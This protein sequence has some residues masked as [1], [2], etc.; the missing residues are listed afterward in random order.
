V[1]E[2]FQC[3]L[4]AL[5]HDMARRYPDH[6][7]LVY[8]DRDLRYSFRELDERVT[9]LAKGL[10]AL[11]IRKG[12]HVGIW[13]TNVPDWIPIMF[14]TARIGAVLVTVNTSYRPKE[15]E[16]VLQQSDMKALFTID[17]YRDVDYVQEI[18]GLVPELKSG[19][20]GALRSARFPFLERV[21]YLGPKK[22]RGMH[23]L[24][25]VLRLA[26]EAGDVALESVVSSLDPH[27]VINMQYTS[28]TTGFPKGVML[29]HHSI[30]NNGYQIGERQMFTHR[31]RL[32]LPVPLFHCF[33][34]TLGVLAAYT[35]G[36]TIVPLETFDPLMVLAVVQKERCTALYGV[37][38]MFIAELSHPMFNMFD[39]QSLRT[40]IM[41]GSPCPEPVMKHVMEKMHCREITIVYGLTEASPGITQTRTND[42]VE[43]RV[44]TVGKPFEGVEVRIVDPETGAVLPD[45]TPG[46]LCSRG[47]NTMKG[48]YKMPHETAAA[49]DSE[50][51]LR[52]GDTAM[53]TEDGY[54]KI[55]GRLKD[56]IIRGGENIYP[57]EVEDFLHGVPGI[58]D[59]QIV[60]VPSEKYGEEVAAYVQLHKDIALEAGDIEDFCRG[61]IARY[62][63]PKYVFFVD[64][65]PMTTSGKIQKFKLRED[66]AARLGISR[67]AITGQ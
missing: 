17:G 22:H 40:G 42:P 37:P 7:A 3:T 23:G 35:H 51:W 50:G 65:F 59:V 49:I 53:S 57:K 29:T 31:D 47:Y 10:L 26:D 33:G 2:E 4:G 66:A 32:C 20:K 14:A 5:L 21:I 62:K 64:S 34:I 28:G 9:R 11:G 36:S 16:Y 30:I 12:D 54:Y 39:L 41:A 19:T 8:S 45:N 56:L 18:Y 15:L 43:V 27:D 44:K 67:T 60:G 6:A 61:K 63:I 48:Y 46:E 55:T 13:A 24:D 58:R 38:T 1:S 52:T 25:E